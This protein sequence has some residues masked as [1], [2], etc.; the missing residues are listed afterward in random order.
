MQTDYIIIGAGTA[1]CLLAHRLSEGGAGVVLLEAGPRAWHPMI[2]VPAGV[3][4]LHRNPRVN[5]NFMTEPDAGIDGRTMHWSRGKVIG[6]S[7]SINGMLYVRG[8]PADYDGWARGG[9]AGWGYADILPYFKKS[10]SYAKGDDRY[11]GKAGPMIVEDY[12]TVL[13]LTDRFVAAAR[14]AGIPLTSDY[15]G[16][17]QEGVGYS[18]MTRLGRFRGS[19]ASTFLRVARGRLNLRVATRAMVTKLLIDGGRCR[20]VLYRQGGV[21]HTLHAEREVII[22]AGSIKSPHLLQLSGIGPAMH[23]SSHGIDVVHDS[24]GVGANLSDHYVG[25][26]AFRVK[27]AVSINELARGWRLGREILRWLFTANGALT[28][29]V[30]SSTV[31][32]RSR[33][34]LASPD[35]QL[36]FTPASYDQ[37]RFGELERNPGVTVAVCAVQPKSRGTVMARSNNPF[38]SPAI[39]PNYLSVPADLRTILAG[40]RRVRDIFSQSVIARHVVCETLPGAD[41]RSDDE[42]ARVVRKTGTTIYHPVGTCKMGGDAMAVVDSRLRVHGIEGLRIADASVMPSV[43]TGNTNAPTMMIAEKAAVMILEDADR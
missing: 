40:M 10:E 29:G 16:A 38:E 24:P 21:D 22:A 5:W 1:G 32:T 19:T 8:N 14:A 37:S 35:L 3:R 28:F 15:N 41:A 4:S 31:F 39:Q 12:R 43:T 34:G 42:I 20:G 13:P 25:F 33:E 27:D 30:T 26:T 36:L 2:H 6:G 7:G 23:L 9:C 11:R 18:Q 17:Q